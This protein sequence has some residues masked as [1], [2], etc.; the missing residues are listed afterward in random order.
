MSRN[1]HTDFS[2]DIVNKKKESNN[3]P[4]FNT[5]P[6]FNNALIFM[7]VT[8]LVITSVFFSFDSR[9]VSY[10]EESQ[11][12]ISNDKETKQSRVSDNKD[13]ESKSKNVLDKIS[14]ISE[15]P[16][17]RTAGTTTFDIG[18]DRM[19]SVFHGE[20]VRYEDENGKLKDYDSSLIKVDMQKET[21]QGRSLADYS[22]ENKQGDKKQYFP[23]KI[24]E[25]TPILMEYEDYRI[26]FTPTN[27]T[28]KNFLENEKS[29]AILKGDRTNIYTDTENVNLNA[30]YSS[31]NGETTFSYK[32]QPNGI[33]ETI[34]L[35]EVPKTNI[36]AYEIAL[37]GL[38]AKI[39]KLGTI[40]FYD[41][42]KLVGG[43]SK[44]FMNDASKDA[45]STDIEYELEKV[46][47]KD[48]TYILKMIVSEEYLNDK[49]RKYPVIIDPDITW[50]GESDVIEAIVNE[51]Y[52]DYNYSNDFLDTM[53]TGRKD[54]ELFRSYFKFN[55]LESFLSGKQIDNAWFEMMK[56]DYEGT[57]QY[58]EICKVDDEWDEE[59]IIWD[60][61]PSY[62]FCYA[63]SSLGKKYKRTINLYEYVDD[64]SSGVIDD[65][66]L[67]LILY[68]D[69]EE[70]YESETCG[71][72]EFTGSRYIEEENRPALYITY[73]S[74]PPIPAV[75]PTAGAVNISFTD[76]NSPVNGKKWTKDANPEVSFSG[77]IEQP[78]HPI[79][80][81]YFH[82]AIKEN[83]SIPTSKD[84]KSA[85]SLSCTKQGHTYSGTFRLTPADRNIKSGEY[86]IYL[87]A[88][89][90]AGQY[91]E[92]VDVPY[93]KDAD[94]PSLSID[95]SI[96][97]IPTTKLSGTVKLDLTLSDIAGDVI[98][99]SSIKIYKDTGN[100]I[101]G[102][103]GKNLCSPGFTSDKNIDFDTSDY[104][105]GS[106]V[107]KFEAKDHAGNQSEIS[108]SVSIYNTY[109]IPASF[110]IKR[111][112][113]SGNKPLFMFSPGARTLTLETSQGNTLPGNIKW[114]V[115]G[116]L[117]T[118]GNS[119]TDNFSPPKY[120]YDKKYGI[121]AVGQNNST[122]LLSFSNSIIKD[123]ETV[124]LKNHINIGS[125][126]VDFE[127]D[128]V[129]FRIDVENPE[130]L[131]FIKIP[132]GK[133]KWDEIDPGE[134]CYI[135]DYA[136]EYIDNGIRINI[137]SSGG[138]NGSDL[139]EVTLSTYILEDEYFSVYDDSFLGN[140]PSNVKVAGA[141]NYKTYITWNNEITDKMPDNVSYQVH[142]STSSN[143]TPSDSTL[144]ADNIRAGYYSEMLTGYLGKLYY[145]VCAVVK[146]E[147][148]YQRGAFS[149]EVN[150]NVSQASDFELRTGIKDL[151]EYANL[152]MPVGTGYIEKS[153]GNFLYEQT[154]IEISN[155]A[156]PVELKRTYNSKMAEQGSFGRGFTHNF[157]KEILSVNTGGNPLN[158][159]KILF[160]DE[161]GAIYEFNAIIT[162]PGIYKP[163]S[164][165]F[166]DLKKLD[167]T[168]S[169]A[170]K[171]PE[172]TPGTSG[173]QTYKNIS[174]YY[175]YVL[176]DKALTEY[177]FN[178]SGQLVCEIDSNGNFL[179]LEY[180]T[181]IGLLKR[182]S[183]SKNVALEFKYENNTPGIPQ[184]NEVLLHGGGKLN[185]YYSGS[186]SNKTLANAQRLSSK[187]DGQSITY[188]YDY[189]FG[190]IGTKKL[191]GIYDGEGNK[192]KVDYSGEKA[193]ELSFPGGESLYFEYEDSG[194]GLSFSETRTTTQRYIGNMSFG[195]ETEIYDKSKGLLKK[196]TDPLGEVSNYTYT[197]DD[198]IKTS[199]FTHHYQSMDQ[200]TGVITDQS[201]L[202]TET[203]T[204]TSAG[205]I[206]QIT[207]EN[208]GTETYSYGTSISAI[209]EQPTSEIEKD[210]TGAIISNVEND[211]DPNGNQTDSSDNISDESGSFVYDDDG[212]VIS[213]EY[214]ING[215]EV[216]KVEYSYLYFPDG[217]SQ[218]IATETEGTSVITSTAIYDALGNE[219]YIKDS[220]VYEEGT[221][222][223]GFG[224]ILK[225]VV[226]EGGIV[227]SESSTY[228]ANGT[229]TS[230]TDI[231]GLKTSY[232]YD[233]RNRLISEIHS[234]GNESR[235][236]TTVYGTAN[237]TPKSGINQSS[238]NVETTEVK[239]QGNVSISKSFVDMMGNTVRE[240][241][242][243]LSTDYVYTK[244]GD[245]LTTC[246]VSKNG[247]TGIVSISLTDDKGNNYAEILAPEVNAGKYK[248]GTESITAKKEFYPD[249]SVKAEI[250]ALG[251]KTEY[252]LDE[253]KRIT[254]VKT[255]DQNTT[256]YQYIDA[257]SNG[258]SSVTTTDAKGNKS[259]EIDNVR[260]LNIEIIDK[261]NG[262]VTPIKRH[263]EYDETKDL[264]VHEDAGYETIGN[265][266][267]EYFYDDK[268]RLSSIESG[269]YSKKGKSI[270]MT[271]YYFT[272]FT[273][274]LS[275]NVTSMVDYDDNDPIYSSRY[276]NYKYDY[277]KRLTGF[278][279][280]DSNFYPNANEINSKMIHYSFDALDDL[281]DIDYP[282]SV[283]GQVKGL[284]Y[285]YDSNKW[286]IKI[287]A[288]TSSGNKLM[289]EYIYDDF[290]KVTSIKDYRYFMA[291][292]SSYIQKDYVYDNFERVT[293]INVSDSTNLSVKKEQ[294]S[295]QYDK[296]SNIITENIKN[297]YPVNS[298]EKTN[299]SKKYLYD[300]MDRLVTTTSS[301]ISS[302]TNSAI[303]Y[304]YDIVGNM[305][306]E[307][308]ESSNTSYSYNSLDQL[309]NKNV[310]NAGLLISDIGYFYDVDGN[311]V[312]MTDSVSGKNAD[313]EYDPE[314]RLISYTATDGGISFT[315][316]NRYNGY[317]Q[318]IKKTEGNTAT[319]YFYQG[320]SVLYTTDGNNN[321]TGFNFI[322][323]EDNVIATERHDVSSGQDYYFYNKDIR[324]STTNLLNTSGNSVT[325]YK[326]T[327]FGE[328]T[329]N[330]D[331]NFHNEIAY[332]GGIYDCSTELYYLN[333]RF[334]DPSDKRF[335]TQD[336]YRGEFDDPGTWH[337][338]AYCAN[339]PIKYIDPTGHFVQIVVTVGFGAW[340]AYDGY[341]YAKK[342]KLT[343]W[344][345]AGAIAGGAALGVIPVGK[346]IKGGK[347]VVKG[348]KA[349]KT[350]KKAKKI[351]KSPKKTVKKKFTPKKNK[352]T[353]Q[354]TKA[355]KTNPKKSKAKKSSGKCFV[356]GTLVA[357][358][359]GSK[360]IEEIKEGEFVYSKNPKTGEKALKPVVQ[361]FVN[362]TDELVHLYINGEKIKST[363]GHPFWVPK[364]GWT[365][366]IKLKAGDKFISLNGQLVVLEKIQHEIL[367]SPETIYNFEVRDFHTY[368]VGKNRIL[369]HNTSTA[370]PS[371]P[372]LLSNSA[373]KDFVKKKGYSSVEK[374][375]EGYVGKNAT[376]K[377]DL[378]VDKSTKRIW[379]LNKNG[380]S[381]IYTGYTW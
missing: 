32:S 330:G 128:A 209:T 264:L 37:R 18:N 292:T 361:T 219:I 22:Y 7:L 127:N 360:P 309:I 165:E 303:K 238:V 115:D 224:R 290:G 327:D 40:G 359:D 293:G 183:T 176:K 339:N 260:G 304:S 367:E 139:G 244:S 225:T 174:F 152:D 230:E 50:V 94:A 95:T 353:K 135:Y 84:Y 346:A 270:C 272:G 173:N 146:L 90:T 96:N 202:K 113:G 130:N 38:T 88:G 351:T 53:I 116:D 62:S 255:P 250:D 68:D 271:P 217:R 341:K 49:D 218:V 179:Y 310:T 281:T 85:N 166:I 141:S 36:F 180:Y 215:V 235:T 374:F 326:Y 126:I 380:K 287:Y 191:N 349:I 245:I 348:A 35:N 148:S 132:Y 46:K 52:P 114:Y 338:Y 256:Q 253:Q 29:V 370:A 147:T 328:T 257:D 56:Y 1:G 20:S 72:G 318:R 261:G 111:P 284:K 207:D 156:V 302:G 273:Y 57:N 227:T 231:E 285:E 185:Y 321:N 149:N 210:Y 14:Y 60:D 243:G 117:A 369:V 282:S 252:T 154:D 298:S 137:E 336:A 178:D 263:M 314:N 23:E 337:L 299:L 100:E 21:N 377:F 203:T 9:S 51:A 300:N 170:I 249:G 140:A 163:G 82:Y 193:D 294:Y 133:N 67:A 120:V 144:V 138:G 63:D 265:P 288:K 28:A 279:E 204:Y 355:K 92:S 181:D 357:S 222:Y 167:T 345:K 366:A 269:Y 242:Q 229:L 182:V 325:S 13:I 164:V 347:T 158:N 248:T 11:T 356:K 70:E 5:F 197:T 189:T 354:K 59:T 228:D 276:T 283:A 3:R 317:G 177:L 241:S 232:D 44:A 212:E 108:K 233:S 259:V 26:S 81:M 205:A 34:T 6:L 295:Y 195:T 371:S 286:L 103:T 171:V 112:F 344:K 121:F 211:Y 77:F 119:L 101:P 30:V 335:I 201:V 274:D 186:G 24:S 17:E 74:P 277:L 379:L 71:Y 184:I 352:P 376:S 213:E 97:G 98:T 55:G 372:N 323:L 89:N 333:A 80:P 340:G 19:L 226:T 329:I 99:G 220:T 150:L 145:K 104:T 206:R 221:H 161:D 142:R 320:S 118:S 214:D 194:N 247:A 136:E 91:S 332:T 196:Y 223:D 311:Q 239:G 316:K 73:D 251:N 160:K 15:I 301:S 322:G 240:T 169:M 76:N 358:A 234:K 69:N 42:K 106:Y 125:T 312:T 105:N 278:S 368:Y 155:E 16:K 43:I 172:K 297:D 41:K 198:Q 129:M 48:D 375:K 87:R 365:K 267:K 364:K 102:G 25:E 378:Y 342:K 175:D 254:K 308:E 12:K 258:N 313:M 162:N 131:N 31:G 275:G 190:I 134:E 4:F 188:D 143:F 93:Y 33:K 246:E 66:G 64:I 123:Y 109:T 291:G 296:N 122:G 83:G 8:T 200:I 151:W 266:Y 187:N 199:S 306:T 54:D 373:A 157:D 124:D 331:Q 362:T 65:N 47:D 79:I 280:I 107:L 381:P 110:K 153:D 324:D 363:P 334:Y 27:D 289:R 236:F 10:A 315:Q 58:V 216:G 75:P 39:G 268:D 350:A 343:G 78:E 307:S 208:G 168:S 305:L 192:Y 86:D 61:K 237:I 262:S 2:R 319:N 45:Y 159:E